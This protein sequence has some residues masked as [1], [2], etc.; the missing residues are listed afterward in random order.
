MNNPTLRVITAAFIAHLIPAATHAAEPTQAAPSKPNLV[1]I[2]IDDLGYGDIGPFGNTKLKTPNLDRMAAE[3]MKFTSFYATP[4]CSMS[5]ACLMTGCYNARV[6]VPG[7]YFPGNKQGLH[8]DE[9][10][11]ADLVKTQGYATT[12]IGKWHLGHR[13][14]SLPTEQGFDSYFGIPYSNDMTIDPEHARFAKDCVFREGM[15]AEKARA[16]AIRNKV[17]LMRDKEVVEYPADQDTLTRRYTEE[18]VRFIETNS[19]K[20]FFLYL[21]HTMVHGPLA[22][23]AEF[24]GKSAGGLFGD[25]VEEVDWSVGRILDTLKDLKLDEKTLVIFTS[26]NGA[27]GGSSL[28][29]R[30]KKGSFFEGG[31]REPCIMRWPGR[32]PAGTTCNRI[33]GNIDLLPTFANLTG[34]KLPTDR[35][36]DGRDIT[37]LMFKPD[38]P[39]VRRT[40]LY[41]TGG[42]KVAAIRQDDWKLFITSP[43]KPRNQPPAKKGAADKKAAGTISPPDGK[44]LE[45]AKPALELDLRAGDKIIQ[46]DDIKDPRFEPDLRSRAVLAEMKAGLML[47]VVPALSLF[48][49]ATDPGETKNVAAEHPDIVA[50]LQA[51][52]TEHEAEISKNKRP[53]GTVE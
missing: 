20:P 33:A 7:V 5:R 6:S 27:A 28:P 8:P 43:N 22:A 3:G 25:A 48:D 11:L 40:H 41:F 16:E 26:D 23:S 12:C 34:A 44:V 52:A 32:I 42:P 36:I 29:W 30:G 4:V 38:A 24:R 46:I 9:V 47:D 50:K 21:P 15:T 45:G 1:L 39:A 14:P 35:V 31:V 13:D 51:S 18:A 49:L 37:S 10:T 17:P 19:E 53:A 2:F